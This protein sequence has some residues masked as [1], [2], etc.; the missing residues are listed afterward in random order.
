MRLYRIAKTEQI[1]DLSG[2][3]ARLYGGRWNHRGVAVV[4]ASESR[5]LATVEYLVHLPQPF[6]PVNLSLAVIE[7]PD[8]VVPEEI[9]TSALPK[10]WR[11]FPAP[12]KLADL[13]TSWARKKSSLLLRVPSAVVP[14]E[15]N[16]LINPAHP[17]M[18]RVILAEME[19]FSFDSR[20][21]RGK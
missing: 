9:S 2:I 19:R 1:T 20:L 5:S 21:L 12:S 16:V 3:G 6:A 8:D 13:G 14:N 11:N 17:D 15:C 18:S 7:I 10:N 4:Y